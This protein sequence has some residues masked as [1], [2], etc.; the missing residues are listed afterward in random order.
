[1]SIVHPIKVAQPIHTLWSVQHTLQIYQLITFLHVL[2]VSLQYFFNVISKNV[3]FCVSQ[4]FHQ[5]FPCEGCLAF[6]TYP[7]LQNGFINLVRSMH[8]CSY[9]ARNDYPSVVFK[10]ECSKCF[11]VCANSFRNVNLSISA[12]KFQQFSQNWCITCSKYKYTGKVLK[13][14]IIS[15]ST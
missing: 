6:S 1:M 7:P 9:N 3:Q 11:V 15:I 14:A 8:L 2:A 13:S 5:S 12:W 4:T 10:Q